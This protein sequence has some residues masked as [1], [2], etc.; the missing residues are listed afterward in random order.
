M[1]G[2]DNETYAMRLDLIRNL[3]AI[4]LPGG[5]VLITGGRHKGKS[6]RVAKIS[7]VL[8]LEGTDGSTFTASVNNVTP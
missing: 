7:V 8:T 4:P 2:S 6:G 3:A 1:A 5:S